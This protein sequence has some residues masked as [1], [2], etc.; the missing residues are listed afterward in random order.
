MRLDDDT[1]DVMRY[2]IGDKIFL[3]HYRSIDIS[4]MLDE[5][6]K[7]DLW[8]L[9]LAVRYSTRFLLHASGS[10]TDKME[11]EYLEGLYEY[12]EKRGIEYCS[13]QM[14]EEYGFMY[15]FMNNIINDETFQ[16]TE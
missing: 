2:L 14:Y 3:P 11:M 12:C 9:E 7:I 4:K 5:D 15:R 13:A 10:S 16:P 8:L 6:N 1:R